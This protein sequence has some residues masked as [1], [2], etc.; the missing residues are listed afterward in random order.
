MPAASA[1]TAAALIPP[2]PTLAALRGDCRHLS[3]ER[4]VPEK[5]TPSLALA[6]KGGVTFFDRG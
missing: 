1:S 3:H 2:H 6:L 4:R 5:H